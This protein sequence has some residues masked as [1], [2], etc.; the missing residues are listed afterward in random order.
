MYLLSP[1]TTHDDEQHV[2]DLTHDTFA[3]IKTEQGILVDFAGFP[4]KMID[5]LERCLDNNAAP[6]FQAVLQ[7]DVF[8]V[9]EVNDFKHVPHIRL[10]LTSSS[11]ADCKQLLTF[12][13]AE[14]QQ[15][16]AA[17]SERAAA[18][19]HELHACNAALQQCREHATKAQ[20]DTQEAHLAVMHAMQD[21]HQQQRGRLEWQLKEALSMQGGLENRVQDLTQRLAAAEAQRDAAA[22]D[23]LSLRDS[24]QQLASQLREAAEKREAAAVLQAL[25]DRQAAQ[26]EAL[27]AHCEALQTQA[28]EQAAESQRAQQAVHAGKEERA[29]LQARVAE[30]VG[31]AERAEAAQ[32]TA[33]DIAGRAEGELK[34]AQAMIDWLNQQMNE[35]WIGAGKARSV[36]RMPPSGSTRQCAPPPALALRSKVGRMLAGRLPPQ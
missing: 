11:D 1:Q 18:L 32:Q 35:A 16:C 6:R 28:R 22:A 21:E 12:R 5:L 20:V 9:V 3:A 34:E 31:R 30:L 23:A 25:T 8:Q 24:L 29:V 36:A 7:G 2:L 19:E 27:E 4:A 33:E 14:V 26:L 17:A 10:Q 15:Q 13:L